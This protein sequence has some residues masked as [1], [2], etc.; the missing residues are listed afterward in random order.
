MSSKLNHHFVPKYLFRLHSGKAAN[1]H[2]LRRNSG[3]VIWN[4][5]I[6]GQCARHKYYGSKEFEDWLE[7][8]DGL[9]ADAFRAVVRNA[10]ESP[11]KLTDRQITSLYQSV[12][13]QRARV[14]RTAESNAAWMNQT[15]MY[16]FREFAKHL[17]D[18]DMRSQT[19]KAIERGEVHFEGFDFEALMHSIRTYVQVT[20]GILDLRILIV[21][22]KTGYPFVFGDCPCIFYNRRLYE[23][24]DRGVLGVRTPG[25][26]IIHPIHP[27]TILMLYDADSYSISQ[28]DGFAEVITKADVSQFNA[29]QL[30][31]AMENIYFYCPDSV[32]YLLD[33]HA[34]HRATFQ[35]DFGVLR[36]HPAGHLI[37]SGK[38]SSDDAI[39]VFERQ[40]PHRLDLSFVQTREPPQD[41]NLALSRG[42]NLD[43]I[44]AQQMRSRTG[45]VKAED[46][47]QELESRFKRK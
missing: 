28:T 33:L 45:A 13:L 41:R 21:R 36:I 20:A 40:L 18:E 7:R 37:V 25:L 3:E 35:N 29:L 9:H 6:R 1:I 23:W 16:V 39:H 22:N 11:Q 34:A 14:P 4:A 10:W 44:L 30:H 19:L 17:P 12:M 38:A 26:M 24:G 32:E 42:N 8:L 15:S 43:A 2:L 46:V 27:T 5:S 47:V 31:S